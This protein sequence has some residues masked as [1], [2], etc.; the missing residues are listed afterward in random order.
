MRY[1]VRHGHAGDKH[2][3]AGA[4][5]DRPLSSTGQREAR[6][7]VALLAGYS[8]DK[9]VSSPALRCAQTVQPLAEQRGLVVRTEVALLL[10]SSGANVVMC[11][12]GELIR[13]LLGRLL[14]FGAPLGDELTWPKG[15][16]WALEAVDGTITRA[17]YLPPR[18]IE[19]WPRPHPRTVQPSR[20]RRRRDMREPDADWN[21]RERQESELQRLDRNF[22]ELLQELRVAQTGVQILF[23]FLLTLAFTQRFGEVTGFQGGLYY[24][25]LVAA[26]LATSLLIAPVSLHRLLFRRHQKGRVV[27]AANRLDVGGLVALWLALVRVLWF[28]ALWFAMPLVWIGQRRP[29][30]ELPEEPEPADRR[31]RPGGMGD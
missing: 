6:G 30:R 5:D 28:G 1:L 13:P 21:R 12:H 31:G 15:S 8:V 2:L 4:D 10:D 14:E 22:N 20:P 18:R 11:T 27:I 9:I 3:W 26:A 17:T 19:H 24:G 16:V 7:L 29:S 25:T 23:A